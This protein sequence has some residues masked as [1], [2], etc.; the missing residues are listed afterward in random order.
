MGLNVRNPI[1]T[2]Q[3]KN[4]PAELQRLARI[5]KFCME[6]VCLLQYFLDNE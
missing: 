3:D 1:L 4:Q 2:K 6:Q 5:L